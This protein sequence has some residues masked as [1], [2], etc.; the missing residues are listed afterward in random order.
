MQ[1]FIGVVPPE[2]ELEK[3]KEFR[4]QWPANRIDDLVEPHITLKAQGGLSADESW[5]ENIKEAAAGFPGFPVQLGEPRFFGED[6]LYLSMDSPELQEL[7]ETLVKAAGATPEQI[8]QYFELD[9]FVAHLT[10]A[11]TAYG[12]SR[13]ELKEMAAAASKELAPYPAFTIESIRI[14]RKSDGQQGYV[15]YMDVP[16]KKDR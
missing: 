2:S 14:Y 4:N 10:L 6:I 12:L 8:E 13:E 1:Y 7:H 15:K 16:L 9:L 11:K 3:L 5:L